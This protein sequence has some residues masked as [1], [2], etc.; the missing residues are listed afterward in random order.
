MVNK[1]LSHLLKGIFWGSTIFISNAILA[2]ITNSSGI[3]LFQERLAFNAVGYL[4]FGIALSF[5][6][7]IL[8]I[9]RLTMTKKI[10]IHIVLLACSI[11]GIGFIFGWISVGSP[12]VIFVVLVQFAIFY[13]VIWIAQYLY[14]KRQIEEV[15]DA[16]KKRNMEE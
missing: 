1:I 5:C 15:N 13:G 16:L 7:I 14:E 10:A 12:F 2:D 3:Y 6:Q 8:E 4:L 11:L 9:E